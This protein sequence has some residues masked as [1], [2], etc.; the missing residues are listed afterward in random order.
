MVENLAVE[1]LLETRFINEC[2]R[3]IFLTR[4]KFVPWHLRLLATIT[5]KTTIIPIYA[6]INVLD[7]NANSNYDVVR[8]D[9]HFIQV[10][11]HITIAAHTQS[12]ILLRCEGSGLMKT[13]THCNIMERRCSIAAKILIEILS[14]MPPYVYIANLTAK[15]MK[16]PKFMI[17]SILLEAPTS[18]VHA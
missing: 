8:A 2:I 7:S 6:N 10:A 15:P 17:F 11:R 14:E 4:R 5:T 18:V 9:N 3:G 1:I 13:E 16:L 12:T